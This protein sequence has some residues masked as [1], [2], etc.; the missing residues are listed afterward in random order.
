MNS[1]IELLIVGHALSIFLL[2]TFLICV[3]FGLIAPDQFQ[4]H[5]AWSPFLPGFEWLTPT[6]FIAGSVGAYL[7][8][9][10]IAVI[11]VPLYNFFVRRRAKS[12]V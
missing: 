9:W 6:G 1:K 8:G 12:D 10:Y 2:I 11:F 7:Y 3:V 4:M 5:K